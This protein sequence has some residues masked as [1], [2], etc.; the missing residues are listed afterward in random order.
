MNLL[1]L[2]PL[3]LIQIFILILRNLYHFMQDYFLFDVLE[4]SK[5]KIYANWVYGS[6]K[7]KEN[8]LEKLLKPP[9]CFM[10]VLFGLV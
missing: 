5:G 7:F 4:T 2:Q 10:I 9:R 3:S 8:F 6:L 1:N